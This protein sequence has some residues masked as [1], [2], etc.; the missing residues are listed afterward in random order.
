MT[1][2]ETPAEPAPGPLRR[3]PLVRLADAGRGMSPLAVIMAALLVAVCG[4]AVWLLGP[5]RGHDGRPLGETEGLKLVA[6]ASAGSEVAEV[7]Q[8]A[9]LVTRFGD[10]TP[11]RYERFE[12]AADPVD[13][14]GGPAPDPVVFGWS[15]GHDCCIT[16]FVLDGDTG[17]LLGTVE[18][19]NGEPSAF[20]MPGAAGGTGTHAVMPLW[21]DVTIGQYGTAAQ[22]PMG[23]LVVAWRGGRFALDRGAMLASAPEAPPEWWQQYPGLVGAVIGQDGSGDFVPESGTPDGRGG[24]GRAYRTWLEGLTRELE[25]A[26]MD[27]ADPASFVPLARLMNAYVYKGRVRAGLDAAH[28]AGG[29]DPEALEAG[30]D[31]YFAVLAESRWFGDLDSLNDGQ[32]TAQIDARG[33]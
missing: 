18:Q 33:R 21:D 12:L 24:I 10:A 30:L 6:R 23:R 25:R 17:A 29:A 32:L 28:A 1:Q 31:H 5:G 19:G 7:W 22:A 9:S 13:V 2:R 8:G 4:T 20:V 11:V 15:G 14:G 16:H 27:G 26:Q 3:R